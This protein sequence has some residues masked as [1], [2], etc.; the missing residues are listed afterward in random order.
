MNPQMARET[1]DLA[2]SDR[3]ATAPGC[4]AGFRVR[5]FGSFFKLRLVRVVVQQ[6]G[7]LVEFIEREPECLADIPHCRPSAITDHLTHHRGMTAVILGVNVLNHL[8]AAIVGD[9]DIDIRRLSRFSDRN[10][11]EQQ[12]S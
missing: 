5:L 1:P 4:F 11:S 3:S 8:F 2:G 9:V 7:Q 10:R 12:L 6:F